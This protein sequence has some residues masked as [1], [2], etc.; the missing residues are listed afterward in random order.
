MNK[1][2][3]MWCWSA[4]THVYA[5]GWTRNSH[6]ISVWKLEGDNHL[7]DWKW[8]EECEQ[9][10]VAQVAGSCETSVYKKPDSFLA[11]WETISLSGRTLLYGHNSRLCRF[12]SREYCNT[13]GAQSQNTFWYMGLSPFDRLDQRLDN[14]YKICQLGSKCQSNSSNEYWLNISDTTLSDSAS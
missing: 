10:I 6:G 11:R 4:L 12:K 1:T 5:K 8:D 14:G 3:R 2:I 7:K 13:W 9:I